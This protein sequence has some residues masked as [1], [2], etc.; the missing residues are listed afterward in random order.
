MKPVN[1]EKAAD[2]IVVGG[3]PGLPSSSVRLERGAAGDSRA[4]PVW[5]PS[6]DRDPGRG[7]AGTARPA[8]L[9]G[10][11]LLLT[12][13]CL[14]PGERRRRCPAVRCGQPPRPFIRGG[15]GVLV[16]SGGGHRRLE[17]DPG[18]AVAARRNAGRPPVPVAA[19]ARG[20]RSTT[21]WPCQWR[22]GRPTRRAWGRR[23]H[24]S[25]LAS[26][27]AVDDLG[28]PSGGGAASVRRRAAVVVTSTDPRTPA[29]RAAAHP[30]PLRS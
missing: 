17:N 19:A 9:I 20:S 13:R 2:G 21:G 8:G 28:G 1:R 5:Q 14:G 23:T 15:P 24:S 29:P 12:R 11:C 3:V 25:C 10:Q 27:S 7:R 6:A 18:F 22:P 16:C 30:R 26:L 4:G